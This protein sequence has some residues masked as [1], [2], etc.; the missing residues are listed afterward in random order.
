MPSLVKIS[1]KLLKRIETLLA[2]A[3]PLGR[4]IPIVG[5]FEAL[6]H[7]LGIQHIPTLYSHEFLSGEGAVSTHNAILLGP[8]FFMRGRVQQGFAVTHELSH[9]LR[10]D[11]GMSKKVSE[12]ATDRVAVQ[13]MGSKTAGIACVKEAER[14]FYEYLAMFKLPE[15]SFV[16]RW[17]NRLMDTLKTA[18]LKRQYGT[19]AERLA[20]ILETDV[21][22][23]SHVQRLVSEH[24]K[25]SFRSLP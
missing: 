6:C 12:L 4:D 15:T 14:S 10:G 18:Q 21:A 19:H 11:V 16:G 25:R 17:T 23:K 13:I 8:G 24:N 7:T 1:P 5:E 3:K 20:N 9:L 22:D 2:D